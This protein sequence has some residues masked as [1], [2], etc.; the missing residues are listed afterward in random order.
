MSGLG[1]P[2]PVGRLDR[3]R[4]ASAGVYNAR[5]GYKG[6]G[7]EALPSVRSLLPPTLR[8]SWYVVTG[9]TACPLITGIRSA[10]TVT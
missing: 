8:N 9:P 4:N 7:A 2:E 6:E 10:S 1:Q 3:R 5:Y